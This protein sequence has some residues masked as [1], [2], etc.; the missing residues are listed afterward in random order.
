MRKKLCFYVALAG[1]SLLFASCND[2]KKTENAT[3]TEDQVKQ[4]VEQLADFQ[5]GNHYCTIQT[6]YF[7]LNDADERTKY[8]QLAANGVITYSAEIINDVD[9]ITIKKGKETKKR[10]VLKGQH[11][12][13]KVDLTPEGQALV[14]A[15]S[16]IVNE[17]PTTV[18][19]TGMENVYANEKYESDNVGTEGSIPER[20]PIIND[21]EETVAKKI[22]ESKK[23]E[24]EPTL[25]ELE[26]KK[27]VTKTVKVNTVVKTI[28]QISNIT[29]TE[30]MQSQ[31]YAFAD[32]IIENSEVSPFGRILEKV[33]KG[34][35]EKYHLTFQKN[36]NEWKIINNIPTTFVEKE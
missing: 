27:V 32:I 6:G 5:K 26:L 34:E 15:D 21:D 22:D 19:P 17:E 3:I 31:G 16:A 24:K 23:E 2:S 7:E 30:L 1:V 29:A 35:K 36:G 33:V 8:R 12:F 25:Y 18:L 20:N 14:V 10:A 13:V 9:S 11:V 28:A 4:T